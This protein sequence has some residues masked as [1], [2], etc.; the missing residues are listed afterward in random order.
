[1]IKAV[2]FDVDGVLINS[3][4]ANFKFY[5]DFFQSFGY[6]GFTREWFVENQHIT[7]KDVIRQI[8]KLPDGEI[9]KMWDEGY[10]KKVVYTINL[11]TL[12]P[13][14]FE[15]IPKLSKLYTLGIVTNK[16]KTGKLFQIKG[17]EEL[18]RYFKVAVYFEDVKNPKPNPEGILLALDRL[19]VSPGEA[20][21]IGDMPSDRE[22]ALTAGTKFIAYG[23]EKMKDAEIWTPDF[24]NIPHL[25]SILNKDK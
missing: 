23:R 10:N 21:Y 22:T 3:F 1:M 19:K 18:E 16:T 4:E 15:T 13:G 20:V 24:S 7:F 8:T 2:L 12:M 14:V 6:S 25:T 5:S 17:M 9:Q 11:I